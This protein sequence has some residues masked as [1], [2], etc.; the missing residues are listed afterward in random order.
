MIYEGYYTL[1]DSEGPRSMKGMSDNQQGSYSCS[2]LGDLRISSC[3]LW[4]IG[5]MTR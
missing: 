4:I 2:D 3:F 1:P 5:G